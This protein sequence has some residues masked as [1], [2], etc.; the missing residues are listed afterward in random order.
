MSSTTLDDLHRIPERRPRAYARR[1]RRPTY[2]GAPERN[3]SLAW[4]AL[5]PIT[6]VSVIAAMAL[7]TRMSLGIHEPSP[8]EPRTPTSSAGPELR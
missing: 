2:R 3:P 7:L 4:V 6:M 8:Y 1:V 5:L